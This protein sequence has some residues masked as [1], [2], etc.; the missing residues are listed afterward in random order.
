MLAPF[1]L[2]LLG[3][4]GSLASLWDL[5]ARRV[6]NGL[7]LAIAAAGLWLQLH[8]GGL[9]AAG[10]GLAS[11]MIV[12]VLLWGPWT[13]GRLGGGDL[14]LAVATSLAVGLSRLP[15]FL[16]AAALFGGAAS[17]ICWASSARE[18]RAEIRA[19]LTHAVASATLPRPPRA[20]PGRASVPY[21]PAIALG[22]LVALRL[23]S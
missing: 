22:A 12:A 4:L 10:S 13:S 18:V 7:V 11:G 23:G 19:Q 21:A 1:P 17:L 14:K 9:R 20:S 2:L 5:A 8:A 16:L 6:P 15:A 3:L